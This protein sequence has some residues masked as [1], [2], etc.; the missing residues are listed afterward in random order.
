MRR[1]KAFAGILI[2]Y[3]SGAALAG[4]G[5]KAEMEEGKPYYAAS[6]M[7]DTPIVDYILPE[8]SPNIILDN[9]G[10]QAD[11]EK[12]AALRGASLPAEF[13]LVDAESGEIVYSGAVKNALYDEGLGLYVGS[14]DF[15]DYVREGSFYLE[16]DLIG[17]SRTFSIRED[18]YIELFNSLYEE[19]TEKCGNNTISISEANELLIAY[20]WHPSIFPDVNQDE[21]PDVLVILMNWMDSVN[22]QQLEAGDSLLYAGMSAKFSYLYQK[23]DKEYATNSLK[24]ASAILEQTK[25]AVQKDGELFYVLTELYRASGLAAYR[26][27]ITD[28]KA[29]FENNPSYYEEGPYLYGVMTYMSTRQRVDRDFCSL[30]MEALMDRGEE[31]SDSYKDMLHPVNAKNNGPEDLLKR[32]RELACASYILHSYQYNNILAEFLHYLQ[33]ENQRSVCF[34]ADAENKM[35]YILLLS[36]IVGELRA[37]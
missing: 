30:L 31:I 32:A 25:E 33:G 18:Y 11:G 5:T 35:G 15:S 4:C 16:C 20:E 29:F 27:Q 8:L 34:Y 12:E 17:R 26:N 24:R 22:P 3:M 13:R 28:Y 2:L 37:E 21:I 36:Q 23:Y 7:E 19:L 6:S 14:A 9:A 1:T 10:Y